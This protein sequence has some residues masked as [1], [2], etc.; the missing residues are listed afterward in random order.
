PVQ[1]DRARF[2]DDLYRAQA[3]VALDHELD[4]DVA[5]PPQRRRRRQDPVLVDFLPEL[6]DPGREVRSLRI[7]LQPT[8]VLALPRG[9]A[10]F[11]VS[12][13]LRAYLV[14]DRGVE[15]RPHQTRAA[16]LALFAAGLVASEEP[17]RQLEA[18]AA[19]DVRRPLAV[20]R[21]LRGGG[22]RGRW[23]GRGNVRLP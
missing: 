18:F 10:Q 7:E 6:V 17:R 9:K 13:K 23:R 21:L 12:L 14:V 4:V 11:R 3:S 22:R 15:S 2:L 16:L 8:D 20:C 1:R 19:R 5:T